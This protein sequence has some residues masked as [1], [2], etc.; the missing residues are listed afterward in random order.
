ME[1]SRKMKRGT[2]IIFLILVFIIGMKGERMVGDTLFNNRENILFDGNQDK[3]KA[4][5]ELIDRAL[6]E[7][8]DLGVYGDL[9]GGINEI[10]EK[11]Y[12]KI[13][14]H[15]DSY[16]VSIWPKSGKGGHDFSFT[17][18]KSTGMMSDVAVGEILPE[19]DYDGLPQ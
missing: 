19:P 6:K 5:V 10:A 7:Q 11:M 15:D 2:I 4:A 12:V 9:S 3:K 14:E 17:V 1:C 16:S 18:D 13:S 8:G